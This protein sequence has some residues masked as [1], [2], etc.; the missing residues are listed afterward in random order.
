MRASPAIVLCLAI[1]ALTVNVVVA[2]DHA[3]ES[4]SIAKIE[5][6]GGEVTRDD[7]LPGRPVI[8]IDFQTKTTDAGVNRLKEARPRLEIV[9]QEKRAPFE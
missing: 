7:T 4:K 6:L 9:Q 2:E 3:D 8:G 1:V 5:L